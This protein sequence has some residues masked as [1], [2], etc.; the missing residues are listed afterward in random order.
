MYVCLN[1][2]SSNKLYDLLSSHQCLLENVYISLHHSF[3]KHAYSNILKISPSKTES[4]RLKILI[5][6]IFLLIT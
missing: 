4:F 5:F 3:R 6:F 1:T 2:V